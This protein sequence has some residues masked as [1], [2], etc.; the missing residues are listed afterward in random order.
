M[1]RGL[2][3]LG[4]FLLIYSCS[5]KNPPEFIKVDA[6]ELVSISSDSIHLQAKAY[7]KNPNIVGGKISTDEIKVFVN[8]VDVAKVSADEIEVPARKE[9]TVPLK[10]VIPSKRIFENNKRIFLGGLINSILKSK[11][12]VQF[13]GK[14]KH[15]VFGFKTDFLIDK[16]EE[17]KIK[18]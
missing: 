13:K 2:Y 16:T 11:V 7:F 10:V 9:F 1:K 15:S 17:I 8:D 18:F 4:L 5:V 12:K 6:I 14:L 3:F